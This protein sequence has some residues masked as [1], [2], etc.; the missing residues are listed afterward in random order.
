MFQCHFEDIDRTLH[1][2]LDWKEFKF[3]ED[4]LQQDLLAPLLYDAY[5]S[6]QHA[7]N[8]VNNKCSSMT[9]VQ[10]A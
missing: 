7:S 1:A 4:I 10:T 6:K 5:H 3:F 2:A 9:P 8:Q